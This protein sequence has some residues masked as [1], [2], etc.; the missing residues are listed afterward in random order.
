MSDEALV[1]SKDGN[2]VVSIRAED[3]DTV[4]ATM[5]AGSA[6][7]QSRM[8]LV[9][10]TRRSYARPARIAPA[11]DSPVMA[12]EGSPDQV[13]DDLAQLGTGES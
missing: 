5:G 2:R 6:T 3:D 4:V 11:G 7:Q 1:R 8:A 13:N 12:D 10:A 9:A